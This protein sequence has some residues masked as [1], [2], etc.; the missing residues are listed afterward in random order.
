MRL[1]KKPNE[2]G[3]ISIMNPRIIGP[4]CVSIDW[5][6]VNSKGDIY[7]IDKF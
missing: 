3:L 2:N 4:Y 1:L 6:E 7:I 5:F